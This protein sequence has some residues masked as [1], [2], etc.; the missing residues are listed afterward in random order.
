MRLATLEMFNWLVDHQFSTMSLAIY[1]SLRLG[2]VQ[3]YMQLSTVDQLAPQCLS[4]C[5]LIFING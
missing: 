4:V 3:N 2:S 1:Y 5:K